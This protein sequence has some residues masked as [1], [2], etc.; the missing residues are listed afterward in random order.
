M[1]VLTR[2]VDESIMIGD[3]VRITVVAVK[4]DHVR[5]G[6]DAP[7]SVPIHR[8]EIYEEICRTNVEA[9]ATSAAPDQLAALAGILGRPGGKRP[10]LA[11]AKPDPEA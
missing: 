7:R 10:T 9:S 4:G 3:D 11:P 5:V 8:L 6:V 2:K 1:L